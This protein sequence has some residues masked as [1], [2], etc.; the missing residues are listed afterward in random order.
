MGIIRSPGTAK[1]KRG[2]EVDSVRRV[3]FCERK[4]NM[5][6]TV[7]ACLMAFTLFVGTAA[8][9]GCG[10][11]APTKPGMTA[12]EIAKKKAENDAKAAAAA[13]SQTKPAP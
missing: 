5:I 9:V 3:F 6:K 4:S 12:E 11:D 8:L 13:A 7:L 1:Q 2:D 10:N